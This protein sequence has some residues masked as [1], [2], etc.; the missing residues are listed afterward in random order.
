MSDCSSASRLCDAHDGGCSARAWV[1]EQERQ[2]RGFRARQGLWRRRP[3]ARRRAKAGPRQALRLAPRVTPLGGPEEQLPSGRGAHECQG[4][5]ESVTPISWYR[6]GCRLALLPT[7]QAGRLLGRFHR[8]VPDRLSAPSG[9]L[10]EQRAASTAAALIRRDR[11]GPWTA[12][13]SVPTRRA[14][15]LVRSPRCGA[16]RTGPM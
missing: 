2:V 16:M 11:R 9:S 10:L 6:G 14:R 4:A 1:A 13:V 7:E 3:D 8:V 12:R 5:S 15:R